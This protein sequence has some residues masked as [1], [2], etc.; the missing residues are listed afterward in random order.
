MSSSVPLEHCALKCHS[1]PHRQHTAFA[2]TAATGTMTNPLNCRRSSRR[3][4]GPLIDCFPLPKPLQRDGGFY[5]AARLCF[6]RL[7]QQDE[8]GQMVKRNLVNVFLPVLRFRLLLEAAKSL[9]NCSSSNGSTSAPSYPTSFCSL[10]YCRAHRCLASLPCPDLHRMSARR[11][12]LG[13]LPQ[14]GSCALSLFVEQRW[15]HPRPWQVGTALEPTG[16]RHVYP[17]S[18]SQLSAP[19]AP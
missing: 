12:R 19:P 17:L 8:V 15:S 3:C 5:P 6:F 2:L 13:P 7:L 1:S 18:S 10:R 4:R 14:N 9:I 11:T 16:L